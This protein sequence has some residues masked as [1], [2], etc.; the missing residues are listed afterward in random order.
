MYLALNEQYRVR[1]PGGFL[2]FMVANS[3]HADLPIATDVI[4]GE[5]ARNVS[6]EPMEI[7]VLHRRN[8][9]TRRRRFLRGR[10][11]PKK[12]KLIAGR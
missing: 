5:I 8:D 10:R 3:R 1:R 9:R 11:H 6:F 12:T 7:V 2:V 4:I